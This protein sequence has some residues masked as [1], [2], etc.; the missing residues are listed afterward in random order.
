MA[1]RPLLSNYKLSEREWT[2]LQD[3][4]DF[5]RPFDEVTLMIS[6]ESC[7]AAGFAFGIY[8]YLM[9]VLEKYCEHYYTVPKT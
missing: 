5:L 4:R 7:P 9:S 1:R 8:E 2:Y 3:L 6:S